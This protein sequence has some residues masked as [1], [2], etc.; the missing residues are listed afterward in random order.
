MSIR[1]IEDTPERSEKILRVFRPAH[2]PED[3]R[4]ADIICTRYGVRLA[5]SS[6]SIE[7]RE[8]LETYIHMLRIAF[9]KF[10]LLHEEK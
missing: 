6:I 4:S 2:L 5:E 9:H 1:F 8:D 7:T 10:Q 3:D